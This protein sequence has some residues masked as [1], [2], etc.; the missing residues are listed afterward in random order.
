MRLWK[1]NNPKTRL[2][3]TSKDVVSSPLICALAG[4][5]IIIDN[6]VNS[7]TL[8]YDLAWQKVKWDG[9]RFPVTAKN[10]ML[11]TKMVDIFADNVIYYTVD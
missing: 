2:D 9:T 10:N 3:I 6:N 1:N 7:I 11:I 4:Y 5:Y 8:L